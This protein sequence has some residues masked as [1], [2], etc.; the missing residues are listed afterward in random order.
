[1]R[2]VMAQY[3][4]KAWKWSRPAAVS[5]SDAPRCVL[6][7]GAGADRQSAASPSP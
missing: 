5:G 4:D 2:D 3:W 7:E 6:T 1:V